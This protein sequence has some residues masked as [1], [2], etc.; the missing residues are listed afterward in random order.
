[1]KKISALLIAIS[2]VSAISGCESTSLPPVPTSSNPSKE[3]VETSDE[4]S[5]PDN[6]GIAPPEDS[7][8]LPPVSS[9]AP[10]KLLPEDNYEYVADIHEWADGN[11]LYNGDGTYDFDERYFSEFVPVD[12]PAVLWYNKNGDKTPLDEKYDPAAAVAFAKAHWD[13]DLDLCAPFISRCLRAGGLSISSESSTS[14][15]LKLI[16]SGLGFGQYIPINPD[17]TVTLPDYASEGDVIQ[18]YCPYEGL[19][20]HSLIFVGN[21]ENGNMRVCCHNYKNSGTYAFHTD[22]LCYDCSTPLRDVFYFHFYGENERPADNQNALLSE[23]SGYTFDESYDRRAAAD[24]A[25]YYPEDGLGEYGARHLTECFLQGG[26]SVG[27]PFQSAMFMQLLKSRLGTAYTLP[28]NQNRTVYLPEFAEEGDACFIYCP[29][30]AIMFSSFI[31]SGVDEYGRMTA[32]SYDLMNN[33]QRAF[34]VDSV[35]PGCE[36]EVKEVVLYHFN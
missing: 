17:K 7:D 35:C 15:C 21:D 27:Y 12:E 18:T 9:S 24:Y 34:R 3:P 14:L 28:V 26:V 4:L 6:T 31:I 11:R 16:N 10:P 20:L 22:R 8:F 29:E 5:L 2:L 1:M 13:D 36:S 33:G 19:M 25:K 30:D 32:Y 23:E